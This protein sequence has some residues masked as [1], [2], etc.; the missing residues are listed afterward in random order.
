MAEPLK[1]Y[2][3]QNFF[4]SLVKVLISYYPG[5]DGNKFK[6][7]IFDKDWKN[8]ELKQRMRHIAKVL[9]LILAL[10]YVQ[11]LSILKPVSTHFNGFEYMFFPDYVEL[12][13][14]DNFQQS[15][16][17]L[18]VFT[19]YSSSE[20]AVR[21]FIIKYPEQM[22][23]QMEIWASSDN[24]HLRRLASEGCRPRLPWAMSLPDF[25][26][27]PQAVIPILK[28]LKNDPSEYV[29][30][31][32]A[33][34]LNDISKDNPQSVIDIAKQWLGDCAD[35]N[36]LLKHACR[37]LLKQ[38]NCEV[39]ALFGFT[40]ASHIKI[41][42]FLV[43]K[44][45]CMGDKLNF[46]FILETQKDQL[47]KLRIEYAID[48]MKK[49][50][51]QARKIFKISESNNDRPIKTINKVHSFRPISTRKYYLGVHGIAI[52]IN[53]IELA[54]KRFRLL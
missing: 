27:N 11:A 26:K 52:I 24:H 53:G 22:M 30:R 3:N 14:M 10:D 8:K 4:D 44:N 45:V 18:Q 42:D 6:V 29:R 35:T 33:N 32:V 12:Y 50:G 5:F 9:H 21:A 41:K 40:A 28:I 43:D 38:G 49:N 16:L 13:G 48:F 15:I 47:G 34:N 23:G 7:K 54:S 37:S 31:S 20:F 19:Q 46:S 51:K 2:Y 36:R 1:N 39:L 17:A 25:K